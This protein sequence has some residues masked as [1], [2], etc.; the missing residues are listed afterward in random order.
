VNRREALEEFRQQFE[1]SPEEGYG[2]WP[3]RRRDQ[4]WENFAKTKK[5]RRLTIGDEANEEL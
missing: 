2:C 3:Q 4:R 1:E 5:F